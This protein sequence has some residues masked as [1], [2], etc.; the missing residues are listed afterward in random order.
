[1]TYIASITTYPR[2]FPYF[3]KALKSIQEQTAKPEMIVVN[4]AAEDWEAAE[5]ELLGMDHTVPLMFQRVE[6][7]L[8]PANKLIPT[9]K[10]FGGTIITFD[11]D[12][13]YPKDRAEHLLAYHKKYPYL[14]ISFR[15]RLVSFTGQRVDPYSS[16]KICAGEYGPDPLHFPTGVSGA[17]YPE[18]I[19]DDE[20]LDEDKYLLL[21]ETNDDIWNYFHTLR[22]GLVFVRA[23]LEVVPPS[24]REAQATALMTRNLVHNN[25]AIIK[26]LERWYGSLYNLHQ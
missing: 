20:W 17:L 2:R 18:T 11:D 14:P 16:W 6:K 25:D 22:M 3:L 4:I 26:K 24:I 8:R 12:I 19:F 23:G 13:I 10:S 9:V 5:K 21:S 7:N 1:M 15:T